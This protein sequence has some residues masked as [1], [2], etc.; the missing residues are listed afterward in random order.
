M[1][2]LLVLAAI[3]AGAIIGGDKK[4]VFIS[5]DHSED[6]HLR[7]LLEAWNK[8][9]KFSFTMERTSPFQPIE[10]QDEAVVK[11]ALTPMLKK[12][13]YLLVI[14]GEKTAKSQFVRWE[15]ERAQSKDVNLRIAAVK[16]HAR[17]RLPSPL[18]GRQISCAKTFSHEAIISAL[19]GARQTH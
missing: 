15:I 1:W 13:D 6:V 4:K 14:V 5:Y 9:S 3:V 16:R 10:S 18:L 19:E 8:N 11:R 7:N 12:A 17:C 2:P